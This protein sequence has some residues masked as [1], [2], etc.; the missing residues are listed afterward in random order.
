MIS[1][2]DPEFVSNNFSRLTLGEPRNFS[3][4]I[5]FLPTLKLTKFAFQ[6]LG[7]GGS[8]FVDKMEVSVDECRYF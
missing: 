7:G 4:V 6:P 1:R 3:A 2:K 8:E 5:N